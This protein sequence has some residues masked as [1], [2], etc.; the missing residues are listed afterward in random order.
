MLASQGPRQQLI[1][2][3]CNPCAGGGEAGAGRSLEHSHC[4]A[5]LAVPVNSMFRERLSQRE[6][7]EQPRQT[8]DSDL[9]VSHICTQHTCRHS[10]RHA[11]INLVIKGTIVLFFKTGDAHSDKNSNSGWGGGSMVKGLP[12]IIRS[13]VLIPRNM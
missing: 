9:Q 7:E 6:G 2:A 3:V 10:Y 8:P 1:G 11:Y 4:P 13:S 12:V 5:S